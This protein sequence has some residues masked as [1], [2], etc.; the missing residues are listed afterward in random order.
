V[1]A[2]KVYAKGRIT[3]REITDEAVFD[4]F[5]PIPPILKPTPE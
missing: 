2:I 3:S 4:D 5:I 1:V